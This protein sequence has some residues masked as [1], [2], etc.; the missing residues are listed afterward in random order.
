MGEFVYPPVGRVAERVRRGARRGA[1]RAAAEIL[2][3]LPEK[4]LCCLMRRSKAAAWERLRLR[5]AGCPAETEA[6]GD[7]L[8]CFLEMAVTAFP[9]LSPACRK[10]IATALFANNLVANEL[11]KREFVREKGYDPPFLLVIS[12]TMRCNLS[13]YGCYAGCYSKEDDLPFDEVDRIVGEAKR[14]LG[15]HFITISGG[16]PFIRKD[17]YDLFETHRDVFFQV[18]THGRLIDAERL[19]R[20]GN[21]APAISVEGFRAQTDARRGEGHFDGI[22]SK[23]AEL[24][25]AGVLFGFSA[26]AT[27]ANNEVITSD[28]FIDFWSGQGCAFGWYFNYIPIGRRPDTSLMPSPEQRVARAKRV[29]AIRREKRFLAADFWNDGHLVGGCMAGG[30]L[31][32]HVTCRGDVEPCVFAHFAA[33]NIRGK[34]LK[35]V[36]DGDLFTAIRARQ[37]YTDNLFTPCMIIDNPQVLREVVTLSGAHGTHDG[38]ETIIGPE[39]GAFLDGYAAEMKRRSDPLWREFK[40]QAPVHRQPPQSM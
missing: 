28:E 35:E 15:V 32:M 24:R 4:A 22:V 40:G 21:V 16:E 9:R 38:A 3:Y 26:T 36:L 1:V 2:P 34:S 23:M 11:T 12:P 7:F 37:P 5:Y 17:V 8:D 31:Y 39:I 14:E 25:R 18:Y 20:L 6:I 10:G 19:G 30:K 33:E 13:C 29:H 27:A